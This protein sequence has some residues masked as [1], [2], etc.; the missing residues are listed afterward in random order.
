MP[1]Y[2]VYLTSE[3]IDCVACNLNL[4][5]EATPFSLRSV[6]SPHCDDGQ[7]EYLQRIYCLRQRVLC[8]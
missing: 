6:T 7:D 5:E 4:Y 2:L 8:N 1:S 3:E